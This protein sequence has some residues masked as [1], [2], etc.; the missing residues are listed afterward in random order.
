MLVFFNDNRIY[1]DTYTVIK[2]L[3]DIGPEVD[4]IEIAFKHLVN[5]YDAVCYVPGNHEAWR[6]GILAVKS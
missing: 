1:D 4:R 6:R 3:G 5:N 2:L